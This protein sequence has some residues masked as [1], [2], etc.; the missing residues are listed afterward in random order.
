MKHIS[1]KQNQDVKLWRKLHTAKG[2][3]QAHQYL[4]EGWHLLEEAL[5]ASLSIAH[6]LVEETLLEEVHQRLP[7]LVSPDLITITSDV[8]KELSQTPANQGVFAII[9]HHQ[10]IQESQKLNQGHRWLL[11]DQIQDPGNLGTM[12]RTADAAGYQ[13]IILGEGCVD[14]YN[15]K[16]IRSTQGS[17]WHID[18]LQM[19][20]TE[21]MALLRARGVKIY[22]SAL[23]PQALSYRDIPADHAQAYII[24]NEGQGVSSEIVGLADQTVYIPMKGKAESLNAA[25]A[26]SILM[27]HSM[28]V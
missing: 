11:L 6:V 25:I 16:V 3:R 5:K 9:N 13:G 26:A 23:D 8:S 10:N 1:S 17:L 19:P 15:D 14:P 22:V 21:A 27:F 7:Q 24:G 18:L 28:E 2:R 4:I 12:I 20:L